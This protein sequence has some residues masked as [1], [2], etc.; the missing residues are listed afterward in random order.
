M[1]NSDQEAKTL[2]QKQFGDKAAAYASSA[3]HAQ[4]ASLSRVVELVQP[5]SH[6]LVLDVA[7]AAGH[8]AHIFAPH[9]AQVVATDLTWNML[10]Q[11]RQL[12]EQKKLSNES[13]AAGD[14]ELLPFATHSF[15]L[16]TCRI[17]PHHFPHIDQ[18]VRECKRV[19]KPGGT[20]AIVDNI[21]PDTQSKKKK[22]QVAY[23]AAGQYINAFEKLRD[24]SHGRC[25]G[26]WEWEKML[27]AAGFSHI[28][29]ET[30]RKKMEFDD[31]AGRMVQD[32]ADL[33]R[34]RV[35]LLQAPEVAKQFL[36]PL[37]TGAKIEFF[38]SEAI[39]I[40]KS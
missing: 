14:A 35:M 37:V 12:A 1:S 25:L 5:Q 24:P 40:G 30:A 34:L 22:E 27:K 32:P 23:E 38:L 10:P 18:F 15:D 20:V 21:V 3:V 26:V 2:V 28:Y 9:V 39:F 19:L 17:A 6:W 13:F 8:T 7:A 36:T 11:A 33:T 4:G 29:H 16:V 31:W